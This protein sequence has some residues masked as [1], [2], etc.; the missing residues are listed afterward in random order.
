M[1]DQSGGKKKADRPFVA[2]NPVAFWETKLWEEEK[3]AELCDRIRRELG[4]GVVLTGGEAAPLERI[5]RG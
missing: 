4:I 3:F 5:R 2:V 1:G